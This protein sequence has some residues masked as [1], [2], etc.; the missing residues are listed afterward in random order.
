MGTKLNSSMAI[1]RLVLDLH[2]PAS[3]NPVKT[4][5]THCHRRVK[6]FLAEHGPCS[7]LAQLLDLLANKLGST[8]VE[9]ATDKQLEK[10]QTEYVG[11]GE[12]I[13]ATLDQEFA[14]EDTYGITF[15]LQNPAGWEQPYVSIIDSRGRKRQRR[16]HTKWHELGHL[17][18]LTDQTR[19]AFRRSHDPAHPKSAEESLVD[20]IAGDLSFYRP[21]VAPHLTGELSFEKIEE[22]RATLCPEASMYSAVLNI[23]KLWPTPCIWVEARL[24]SK[25]SEEDTSQQSFGFREPPERALRAVHANANDAARGLGLGVIPRFR[26]PQRSIITRV[27][28]SG[29][30]GEAQEDLGWWESSDGTRLAQ[31]KVTVRAK[32]IGDTIHALIVPN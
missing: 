9:I 7:D 29:T 16:Y 19:F 18:I 32:Q 12:S 15:K 14:D 4:I 27:F 24:A 21:L 25:K 3:D 22:M 2:L 28:E 1:Q 11:R 6:K 30:C 5:L 13:F 8:I 10:L 26:I 17:L 20:S 23:A 31:C